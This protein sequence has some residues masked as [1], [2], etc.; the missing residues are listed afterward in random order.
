[1]AYDKVV[2]NDDGTFKEG[3]DFD[4]VLNKAFGAVTH[5]LV[6]DENTYISKSTN[7]LGH[8]VTNGINTVA[9]SMYTR[10]R[11]AQGKAPIARILF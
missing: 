10:R 11:V 4:G 9:T 1:M 2:M 3:A 5:A 7:L 8:L 6:G